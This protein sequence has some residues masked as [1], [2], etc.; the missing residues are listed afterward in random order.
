M[1]TGRHAREL[2]A[3]LTR[4][5]TEPERARLFKPRLQELIELIELE[6]GH[7]PPAAR[8]AATRL[9]DDV[10]EAQFDNLPV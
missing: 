4:I 1:A 9:G 5:Q 3:L 7:V 10:T 6:G 8:D 2:A